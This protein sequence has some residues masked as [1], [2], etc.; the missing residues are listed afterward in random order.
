M[1]I[2]ATCLQYTMSQRRLIHFSDFHLLLPATSVRLIIT[3]LRRSGWEMLLRE[4]MT[5][6]RWN[7]EVSTDRGSRNTIT[8]TNLTHGISDVQTH[9][10]VRSLFPHSWAWEA[11][12][13]HLKVHI[14]KLLLVQLSQLHPHIYIRRSRFPEVLGWTM[15]ASSWGWDQFLC[16]LVSEHILK[17]WL[18]YSFHDQI[19]VTDRKWVYIILIV[20]CHFPVKHKKKN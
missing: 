9:C 6:K 20:L 4:S 16:H 14:S 17:W 3:E 2:L 5:Q 18:S 10:C 8:T 12:F 11:N 15:D 1:T 19:N 13:R 7:T